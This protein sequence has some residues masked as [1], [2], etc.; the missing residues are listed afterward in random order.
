MRIGRVGGSYCDCP[1]LS[2]TIFK[3]VTR[4]RLSGA[5]SGEEPLPLGFG[6]CRSLPVMVTV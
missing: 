3:L 1:Q 2:L 6:F 4:N 5:A